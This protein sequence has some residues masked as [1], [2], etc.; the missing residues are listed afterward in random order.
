MRLLHAAGEQADPSG[1]IN[2]AIIDSM[3]EVDRL[4]SRRGMLCYMGFNRP[5][6]ITLLSVIL[7]CDPI[8]LSMKK[9]YGE[10]PKVYDADI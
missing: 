5:G 1:F 6:L 2:T 4:C 7:G 10:R 8:R 3:M 9:E